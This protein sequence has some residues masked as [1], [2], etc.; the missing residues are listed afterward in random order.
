MTDARDGN[1][2]DGTP[3]RWIKDRIRDLRPQRKSMSG[4]A[5][6]LDLAPPRIS[7]IIKGERQVKVCELVAMAAYLEMTLEELVARLTR[8]RKV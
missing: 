1:K 3:Q 4:L 5:E 7:E 6:I 8:R 2:T